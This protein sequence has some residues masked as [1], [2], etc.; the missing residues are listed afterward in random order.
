MLIS[1]FP[2]IQRSEPSSRRIKVQADLPGLAVPVLDD[3][4]VRYAVIRCSWLVIRRSIQQS[5][6]ISISFEC[7]AISEIRKARDRWGT[8]LYR[9]TQLR[10]RQNRYVFL[11]SKALESWCETDGDASILMSASANSPSA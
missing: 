8:L 11:A 4:Q 1:L 3:V 10:E 2:Q 6:D 5:D 9:T 7:A